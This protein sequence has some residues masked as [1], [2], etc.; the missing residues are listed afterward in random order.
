MIKHKIIG[1]T[2]LKIGVGELSWM[3]DAMAEGFSGVLRSMLRTPGLLI[4]PRASGNY[5]NDS[6]WQVVDGGGAGKITIKTS[7]NPP[8]IAITKNEKII[9]LLEN[10]TTPDNFIP[11][12]TTKNVIVS[13]ATTMFEPGT[14][15]FPGFNLR[16]ITGIGTKFTEFRSK[17][18]NGRGDRIYISTSG[19]TPTNNGIYEIESITSNTELVVIES[20]LGDGES[21]LQFS[22]AGSFF[23]NNNPADPRIHEFTSAR[24][25]ATVS[26][27]IQ[28]EEFLLASVTRTGDTL[29]INDLRNK[30]PLSQIAQISSGQNG[31][32]LFSPQEYLAETPESISW[33]ADIN[34]QIGTQ[35]FPCIIEA[36]PDEI[37]VF[38]RSVLGSIHIRGKKSILRGTR[39][40][41]SAITNPISQHDPEQPHAVFLRDKT[42]ILT[43]R[44]DQSPFQGIYLTQSTDKGNSWSGAILVQAESGTN[45]QNTSRPFLLETNSGV[46]LCFFLVITSDGDEHWEAKASTDNGFSWGSAVSV[47]AAN[48]ASAIDRC[49]AVV[50]NDGTIFFLSTQTVLGAT[51]LIYAKSTDDGESWLSFGVLNSTLIGTEMDE[52]PGGPSLYPIY[53]ENT[54]EVIFCYINVRGNI[55]FTNPEGP[56]TPN[57]QVVW[58]K[59][60]DPSANDPILFNRDSLILRAYPDYGLTIPPH[61]TGAV[62]MKCGQI[63]LTTVMQP[64]ILVHRVYSVFYGK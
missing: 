41:W 53:I 30:S 64:N 38:F 22:I 28:G 42:I 43:F 50:L 16:T 60:E 17:N 13:P 55:R 39:D 40:T 19:S 11:D 35:S 58:G 9:T 59:I 49:G 33:V 18:A 15:A 57:S 25:S 34:D 27:P 36:D 10:F 37:F 51:N 54:N 56:T 29:I 32:Y 8:A 21:G 46:L 63:L 14:I 3:Q 31:I 52:T 4:V 47:T 20:P 7:S 2:D 26:G 61:W 24:F 5:K 44:K 1:A 45:Y 6:T 12:G 62:K 23:N 48:T